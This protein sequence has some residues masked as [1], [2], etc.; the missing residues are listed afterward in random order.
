MVDNAAVGADQIEPR[1][2]RAAA[3]AGGNH[4]HVRAVQQLGSG[5]RGDLGV[6][7]LRCGVHQVQLLTHDLVFHHVDQGQ[8]L[9]DVLGEEVESE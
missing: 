6:V 3:R 9:A 8:L 5:A 4:N 1:L 2:V 7:H